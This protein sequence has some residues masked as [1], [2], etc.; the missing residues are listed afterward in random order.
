MTVREEWLTD[1]LKIT[2]PVMDHPA[3]GTLRATM[4][5]DFHAER[6][7]FAPL[8]A[9][10]R[11][12]LGL[13]P[14]LE[15]DAAQMPQDEQVLHALWL[16]KVLGALDMATGPASPDFMLFDEGGQPL[17]DTAFRTACTGRLTGCTG[18][19]EPRRRIPCVKKDPGREYKLAVLHRH[20]GGR[21]IRSR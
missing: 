4:P 18:Q 14:W 21:A 6:A 16:E 12:M 2:T 11:S 5:L 20:G 15:A 3:E 19:T 1:L 10:G 17:V 9:F 13:A 8:E 7:R